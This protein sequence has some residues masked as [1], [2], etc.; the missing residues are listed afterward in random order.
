MQVDLN[1]DL[2]EA[3]G[4]YSFG[5]DHQIIPLITSANIACGFHAGDENVMN[6]TV[7]LAKEHGVGIGAHPGFHDLQGFG[8][9]NIDMAPDEIYTLVAYQLGALSA[10]SRIHDVKINHVKPH[11]ALYNMGARDKD[12]AHAIAQAVYDVDPSLILVGLSNTLLISEAE[13]VGLKTASEVFADRRYESNGQL[14]SRKES[15]AVI[16]DTEAAINQV[17]KMVKDNKV[18]AKDGTEIDIQAD[19]ICVHGD[20]AHALEFVSKIRERLTKE[21]ISITKLGG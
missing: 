11:G 17:V 12:I 1:C 7:K 20:G 3:F 21:G 15:D 10:F 8:R 4:N 14:V 16:S 9:R 13:A 5:G 19:T 18:T 6:E 2:G